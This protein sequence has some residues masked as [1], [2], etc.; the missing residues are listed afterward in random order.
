MEKDQTKG[1]SHE[2]KGDIKD[3]VG[4]PT[5]MENSKREGKTGERLDAETDQR[6]TEGSQDDILDMPKE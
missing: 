1:T 4:I 6:Q 5:N 2:V 3:M